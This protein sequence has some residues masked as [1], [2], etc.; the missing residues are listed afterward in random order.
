MYTG[1]E[2]SDLT[3]QFV[4]V[5]ETTGRY[6]KFPVEPGTLKSKR[7][8]TP[9]L[10]VSYMLYER[11]KYFLIV[12]T[13]CLRAKLWF[14]IIYNKSHDNYNKLKTSIIFLNPNSFLNKFC[15]SVVSTGLRH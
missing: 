4:I 3:M 15:K 8:R 13:V 14:M 10:C 2:V 6:S 9:K 7:T 5:V 1:G 12:P 11:P